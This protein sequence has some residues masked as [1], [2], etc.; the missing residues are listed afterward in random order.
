VEV[1]VQHLLA[2]LRQLD[3]G[4]TR[5]LAADTSVTETPSSRMST[6][7]TTLTTTEKYERI[8]SLSPRYLLT[9]FGPVS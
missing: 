7:S 2:F 9:F 5:L 1:T 6:A 8:L 4:W 3:E